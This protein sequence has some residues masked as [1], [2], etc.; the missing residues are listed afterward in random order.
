MKQKKKMTLHDYA[1]RLCEGGQI[2]FNQH[3][4]R[5]EIAL[6]EC[7]TCMLCKMDCI[8]NEDFQELCIECESITHKPH[9]LVLMDGK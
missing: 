3:S 2:W 4:I 5:T 6:G 8:C 7:D 9:I 1:V